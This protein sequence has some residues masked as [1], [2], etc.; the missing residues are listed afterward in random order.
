MVVTHLFQVLGF[1]ALEPPTSLE[2]SALVDAKVE[3][4]KELRPLRP[5][6]VVRGQYEG[7]RDEEG[8]SP[9][10]L[11]CVPLRVAGADGALARAIVRQRR[12]VLGRSGSRSVSGT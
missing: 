3:V 8:V 9:Y 1:V 6:D 10:D 11:V 7:Y 12:P 2:P 4:L 5:E